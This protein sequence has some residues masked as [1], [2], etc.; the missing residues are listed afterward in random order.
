MT[1]PTYLR[2]MALELLVFF[3]IC[4]MVFYFVNGRENLVTAVNT[5]LIATLFY[6]GLTFV[7]RQ[8]AVRNQNQQ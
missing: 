8:R 3:A 2:R 4:S 5:A 7:L 6:G 1:W